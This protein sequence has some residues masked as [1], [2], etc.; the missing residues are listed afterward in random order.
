MMRALPLAAALGSLLLSSS[1]GPQARPAAGKAEA[2]NPDEPYLPPPSARMSPARFPTAQE[3]AAGCDAAS[4]AAIR[5]LEDSGAMVERTYEQYRVRK[6][7]CR[8]AADDPRIAGCRFETASVPGSFG[9]EAGEPRP[10]RESA[11]KPAAARFALVGG[12]DPALGGRLRW[13]AADTCERFVFKAGAMEFDL[14]E[15]ARQKR[16]QQPAK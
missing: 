3:A 13:A 6:L 11:W 10:P 1:A 4:D 8:W 14:R 2:A 15:I 16:A 9:V 7:S 5:E 12:P